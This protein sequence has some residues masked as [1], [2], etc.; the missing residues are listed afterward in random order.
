MALEREGDLRK[1]LGCWT[2]TIYR[3][4]SVPDGEVFGVYTGWKEHEK[5]MGLAAKAVA[6][7]KG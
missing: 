6:K 1:C 2:E 7:A 3:C 5:E 4:L